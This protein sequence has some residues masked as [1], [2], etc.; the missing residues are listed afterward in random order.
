MPHP[1]EHDSHDRP[2]DRREA[3]EIA[4]SM[5]AFSAGSRVRLLFA[6]VSGDRS[7]EELAETVDMDP[8]AVSQQLRVLRQLHFVTAR[9]EGRHVRYR[10]HDHHIEDLL[11]SV[12]HHREHALGSWRD[13]PDPHGPHRS[14]VDETR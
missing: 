3:D 14:T 6:L 11:A 9:R 12:R 8:S 1:L 5:R 4:E 10:L 7:V 13:A 2:I